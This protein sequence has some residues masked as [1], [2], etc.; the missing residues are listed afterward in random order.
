M[1]SD[2]SRAFLP[3]IRSSSPTIKRTENAVHAVHSWA[4]FQNLALI[5]EVELNEQYQRD[6]IF[7]DRNSSDARSIAGS[8]EKVTQESKSMELPFLYLEARR[9]VDEIEIQVI[10]F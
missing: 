6:V 7:Q 9:P 5:T 10:Q 3:S 2:R 1:N 8:S 4:E